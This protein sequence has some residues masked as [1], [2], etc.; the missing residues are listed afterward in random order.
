MTL[1][2]NLDQIHCFV[3]C[4]DETI[5][6]NLCS[7]YNNILHKNRNNIKRGDKF[8]CNE[9]IY[10]IFGYTLFIKDNIYTVLGV[11]EFTDGEIY[12]TLDHIL[13]GNEYVSNSIQYVLSKFT[14]K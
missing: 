6:S 1:I 3:L 4:D 14:K 5:K 7:C 12:I 9:T 11:D 10:N 8:I 2:P 13:Y